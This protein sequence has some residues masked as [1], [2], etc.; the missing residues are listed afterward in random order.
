MILLTK[1]GIFH[2]IS[3]IKANERKPS[4]VLFKFFRAHLDTN[5]SLFCLFYHDDYLTLFNVCLYFFNFLSFK[6]VRFAEKYW[7][8]FVKILF[9]LIIIISR[10]QC[11]AAYSTS[12][13]PKERVTA[14][15]IP[16]D[17]VGP[18]LVDSVEEVFKSAGVPMDFE[19]FFLSE[20]HSALSSP[21][22]TVVESIAR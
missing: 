15:L 13:M 2:N 8:S 4:G 11:L 22:D 3:L 5:K 10:S 6:G 1:K 12:A 7:F 19:V 17:G 9:C 16:G 18:E 21:I 14:T 20:V